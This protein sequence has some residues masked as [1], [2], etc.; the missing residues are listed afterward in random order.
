MTKKYD[1][2]KV[3]LWGVLPLIVLFVLTPYL[4]VIYG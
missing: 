3:F 2:R 1:G 4:V